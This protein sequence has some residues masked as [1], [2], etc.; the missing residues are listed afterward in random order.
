MYVPERALYTS[1]SNALQQL[2][3]L[4]H[5]SGFHYPH[6]PYTAHARYRYRITNGPTAIDPNLWLVHYTMAEP[7]VRLPSSTIPLSRDV[8]AQLSMRAQLQQAGPLVRK[9]FM[10]HDSANWPKVEFGHGAARV[11][12]AYYNPMQPGRSYAQ[13]PPAKRQR[14]PNQQSARQPVPGALVADT[15]L[16]EEENTTQDSFDFMTP[17]DISLSRFKQH[18]EWMEEIYT[19]PHGIHMIQPIDLGLGLMGELA[20]LTADILDAPAG[21]APIDI[22]GEQNPRYSEKVK[23]YHKLQPEQLKEFESRVSAYLVKE[24]AEIDRMKAVHAKKMTDLKR[25]RTYIKAERRLRDIPHDIQPSDAQETG[26]DPLEAAVHDLEKSVGVEFDTKK[27]V[28][29]VDKGGFIEAQQPQPQ[30]AQLNGSGLTPS[31]SNAGSNSIG[32]DGALDGDNTAG[33]LL[34]QFGSGSLTGT[35]GANLS[36]PAL[37]QPQSQSQ[38]AVATP[39][40]PPVDAAQGSS[41]DDQ[42][43]N[44]GSTNAADDLLDLDVEMSGMTNADGK[45]GDDWVLVETQ[46]SSN[47]QQAGANN[48]Q[49][50]TSTDAPADT[51]AITTSGID[52]ETGGMFDTDFGSFDNLDTAGDA[53]ADYTNVGDDNMGLDLVDDSAF[54]DAFHG[55][56]MHHGET[57]DGDN[58]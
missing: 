27:L 20:P 26:T 2:Q 55:T 13:P 23:N 37:S 50:P 57:G 29:C 19:S 24:K 10:L 25:S 15:S 53:L 34:D 35:P 3:V 52:T 42:A 48:M 11:Q 41:F 38:S 32:Q 58:P 7:S 44:L 12:Q 31:N 17:R 46:G 36:V 5:K 1:P 51:N 18:Q 22:N 40:A 8:H 6:E 33:S 9:E 54:G 30:K 49:R 16:E 45:G 47:A 4:V 56:E 21:D 43:A 28:V 39:S 14:L